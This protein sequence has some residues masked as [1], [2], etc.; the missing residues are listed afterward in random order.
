MS[1]KQHFSV[2]EAR[3]IGTRLAFDWAEINLEQFR[4]GLELEHGAGDPETNVTN[5]DPVLTIS[6]T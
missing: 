4:R 5:N 3:A 1:A 2:E 6:A